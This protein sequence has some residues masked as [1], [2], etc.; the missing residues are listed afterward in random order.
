MSKLKFLTILSVGLAV[1]NIALI[2]FFL[3]GRHGEKRQDAPKEHIVK[4]LNLDKKQVDQYDVLIKAHQKKRKGL[5]EKM[6]EL[7]NQLYPIAL[8]DVNESKKNEIL[9]QLQGVYQD[10][11]VANLEHFEDLK[12]LCRADQNEQFDALV[13]ELAHLFVAKRRKKKN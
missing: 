2:A 10:L 12:K 7:R 6:M 3:F 11:E 8:K 4:Q 13:D 9:I 1:I 5:N